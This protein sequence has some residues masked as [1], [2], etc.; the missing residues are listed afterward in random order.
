MSNH[1]D[2]SEGV[3]VLNGGFGQF[4]I[5]VPPINEYLHM[6]MAVPGY[7]P[8]ADFFP[9]FLGVLDRFAN[10]LNWLSEQP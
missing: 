8:D 6:E 4:A 1:P 3:V 2:L 10:E 9:R 7:Q 5:W